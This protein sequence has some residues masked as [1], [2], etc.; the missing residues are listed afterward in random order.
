MRDFQMR[1]STFS[2]RRLA[3]A[4]TPAILFSVLLATHQVFLAERASADAGLG[5]HILR[6]P[7]AQAN[8]IGGQYKGS[9][10][11]APPAFPVSTKTLQGAEVQTTFDQASHDTQVRAGILA[12]LHGAGG[13]T[14]SSLDLECLNGLQIITYEGNLPLPFGNSV[15]VESALMVTSLTA[16]TADGKSTSLG[17]VV[18][19]LKASPT[20]LPG[21]IQGTAATSSPDCTDANGEATATVSPPTSSTGSSIPQIAPVVVSLSNNN[22]RIHVRFTKGTGLVIGIKRLRLSQVNVRNPDNEIKFNPKNEESLTGDTNDFRIQFQEAAGNSQAH[23]CV[24]ITQIHQSSGESSDIIYCP[25]RPQIKLASG[26]SISSYRQPSDNRLSIRNG[27]VTSQENS[28]LRGFSLEYDAS[29]LDL[30]QLIFTFNSLAD[31]SL[32]KVSGKMNIH[33][34]VFAGEFLD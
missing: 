16:R 6:V 5:F 7:R 9:D 28:L 4:M 25:P 1:N 15:I 30:A 22:T 18:S 17:A 19:T 10:S 2:P 26:E 34:N 23:L 3:R 31:P 33:K 13:G 21:P 11:I 29:S 32:A 24:T 8:I 14:S 27:L 12:F 20:A